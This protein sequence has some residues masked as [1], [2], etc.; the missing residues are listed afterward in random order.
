MLATIRAYCASVLSHVT[1]YTSQPAPTTASNEEDNAGNTHRSTPLNDGNEDSELAFLPR[2][3][4]MDVP[5]MMKPQEDMT[6]SQFTATM[7]DVKTAE[8]T[9]E[10][11]MIWTATTI[12]RQKCKTSTSAKTIYEDES[13]VEEKNP[14]STTTSNLKPFM[15]IEEE[16]FADFNSER[17][18]PVKRSYED[19]ESD[20]QVAKRL[21][22]D[23][24]KTRRSALKRRPHPD[25]EEKTIFRCVQFSTVQIFSFGVELG[26]CTVPEDTG[27]PLGMEQEHWHEEWVDLSTIS[28]EAKSHEN[29]P[30]PK[31]PED[32][33]ETGP[34]MSNISNDGQE[35]TEGTKSKTEKKK[36]IGLRKVAKDIRVDRL[37][38]A[39]VTYDEMT[40]YGNEAYQILVSRQA[41]VIKYKTEKRR[42]RRYEESL[43]RME[44][45][46]PFPPQ[47]KRPAQEDQA[48]ST[49]KRYK[50]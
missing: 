14:Q 40:V 22:I 43:R 7:P 39:G 4:N 46:F 8:K 45:N 24:P 28:V 12:P 6:T 33:E 21:R 35:G 1:S 38:D 16:E 29:R 11:E 19:H 5:P 13:K 23:E 30:D 42:K 17:S 44:E 41:E 26:E 20:S 48:E 49:A 18:T 2:D 31:E 27:F 50:H 3:A 32:T 25:E 47:K 37:E 34:N 10:E 9:V 36:R 15:R